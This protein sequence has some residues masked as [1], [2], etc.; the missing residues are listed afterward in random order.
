MGAAR[1]WAIAASVCGGLLTTAPARAQSVGYQLD[2]FE[3]TP[4]GDPFFIVESPWY[5]STRLFAG[6]L[7]LG[8][9]HDLLAARGRDPNGMPID[10]PSPIAHSMMGY[11]VLTGSVFDR[12]GVSAS[13]PMILR[14]TGTAFAGIGPSGTTAGDP[15]LGV[16]VRL[17]GQPDGVFSLSAAGYL[18]VPI[19]SEDDFAGDDGVRGMG[20]LVAGGIL[21]EQVRWAVN[22]SFL[23]RTMARLSENV[24][25]GGNTVGSEVQLSVGAGY[26]AL[27]NKLSLGPEAIVSIGVADLPSAQKRAT[28]EAIGS[29]RYAYGDLQLG[30]GVGGAIAGDGPPDARVLFSLTYAPT[31][32]RSSSFERV[33]VLPDEDGHIGGVEVHDGKQM[34]L[35][36]KPYASTEISKQAPRAKPVQSSPKALPP[37]AAELARVLPASDRDGDGIADASDGCPERAGKAS[38]DPI[39]HG[40]PPAAEKVVV[41]P[42]A[43]G[44]VG[45]VE[46]D[47]GTTK[48]MVDTAYG[49]AEVSVAGKVQAVPPAPARAVDK[50]VAAVAQALPPPDADGDGVLDHDDACP[51]RA[52]LASV[53]P[54]RRGCP[55]SAERV[56]V[57]PDHDGHV[58]GV[59]VDDGKTK[60]LIDRPY[61]A[62]EVAADGVVTAVPAT[63]PRSIE[64]SIAAI[65]NT[66]P[67]ADADQD[68]IPAETDACPERAGPASHDPLR[69]GCPVTVEKVVV[70]PDAD[71]HVGGVEVDDGTRKV[72]LDAAYATS[73]VTSAGVLQAPISP[74]A[75]TVRATAAITK[76]LPVPDRDDD[77][78]ADADDACPE[79][80]G[81]PSAQPIRHGC[82]RS[83]EHVV[84]LA[85][86]NGH[87]GAVEVDDGTTK[88]L[89]D[90]AYASAEIGLDGR[91][92]S[93]PAEPTEVSARFAASMAAQAPGARIILYFTARSAPV[94]DIDG[95]LHNLVAEVQAKATYTIEVIGHTDQTGRESTNIRIGRE[96]A[97]LI[98]GRL[99]ALGV[100]A[101]RITI[102]S[103]GSKEPAIKL[104]SRRI[105][106]LRNR[107]VEIWV[108]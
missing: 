36:D 57:L 41:L 62:V 91:A 27:D 60:T 97:Q 85:D 11:L 42:D 20:R 70:L 66:L 69:H 58:G 89:L 74:A 72:V 38:A 29:A 7:T 26:L 46:V 93:L 33:I 14:Q 92:R 87:V 16:R 106:E 19:G 79:R 13:V 50:T 80:A 77:A 61:A 76:A 88:T 84:V 35:L 53:D 15:R 22:A 105:V 37:R 24:P 75:T 63:S 25:P 55:A 28:V 9:A 4:A 6:G 10:T 49:S 2:R 83:V 8:Y 65:A 104:K 45:G 56:V 86:E 18:W 103:M 96:R 3:P 67:I 94:R 107:R 59:E 99:V 43:D 5:S 1:S 40:C 73:E 100:P 52:G 71:G 47:D 102:K 90:K 21:R 39:R 108:K 12:V 32:S 17:Y 48:V 34:T 82:P 78:I 95:P 54:I 64:R 68:G 23:A 44:H 30:L 81:L 101:D 31:A 51:E 98:A